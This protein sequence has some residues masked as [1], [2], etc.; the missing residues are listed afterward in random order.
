MLLFLDRRAITEDRCL[1]NLKSLARAV[2]KFG[3]LEG[4]IGLI[5]LFNLNLTLWL[6]VLAALAIIELLPSKLRIDQLFLFLKTF[7]DFL[8]QISAIAG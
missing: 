4:R 1:E 8:G 3:L 6:D 2:L 5:D 7:F